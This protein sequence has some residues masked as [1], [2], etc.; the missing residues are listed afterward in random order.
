MM[1]DL[2]KWDG[3]AMYDPDLLKGLWQD[4][5]MFRKTPSDMLNWIDGFN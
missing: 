2:T 3:G 5:M 1:S 4:G